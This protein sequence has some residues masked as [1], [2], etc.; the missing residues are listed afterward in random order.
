[1]NIDRYSG[2]GSEAPQGTN[3]NGGEGNRGA[4]VGNS[5]SGGAKSTNERARR[6][7]FPTQRDGN[8]GG[9]L[10]ER[11]AQSGEGAGRVTERGGTKGGARGLS[12][13]PLMAIQELDFVR[14]EL[15]LYLDTH[16]NC[17]TAIDYYHK[18]VDALEE[19]KA[20]YQAGGT[21]LVASGA[22]D[23]NAWSWI[24][25]PWPWQKEVNGNKGEER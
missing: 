7:G 5:A 11:G 13:N 8:P 25:G 16:P 12:S 3:I 19:L 6:D 15:E 20:E 14:V 24:N 2:I 17:K 21:P 22:I 1:V 9:C 23:T 4:L 18:T 10:W